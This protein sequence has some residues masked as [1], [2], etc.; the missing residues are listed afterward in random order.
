MVRARYLAVGW[1]ALAV[2]AAP[3][4]AVELSPAPTP[5]KADGVGGLA[6]LNAEDVQALRDV[7]E[8]LQLR[9]VDPRVSPDYR[10][11]AVLALARIHEALNDWGLDNQLAWCLDAISAT[12]EHKEVFASLALAAAKGGAYHLGAVC[13]FWSRLDA[14][15]GGSLAPEWRKL[16]ADF[17][18]LSR[19][20]PKRAPRL[21]ESLRPMTLQAKQ[22]DPQSLRTMQVT[23]KTIDLKGSLAPYKP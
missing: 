23:P 17:E 16:H 14:D 2:S 3:L 20:L 4:A 18:R 21:A 13:E 7:R 1:L 9:A 5:G 11:R 22:V 12:K 8:T 10:R 6:G 15:G 19:E